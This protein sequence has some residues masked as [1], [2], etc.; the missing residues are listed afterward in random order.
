[1]FRSDWYTTFIQCYIVMFC[2][3]YLSHFSKLNNNVTRA[4]F[5][6]CN[7]ISFVIDISVIVFVIDKYILFKTKYRGKQKYEFSIRKQIMEMYLKGEGL[8]T[9][10]KCIS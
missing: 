5:I 3:F 9:K 2:Q 4:N 6:C 7:L 8:K 1:M 10:S